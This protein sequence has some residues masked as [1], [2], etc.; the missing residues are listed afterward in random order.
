MSPQGADRAQMYT[1]TRLFLYS[2]AAART[3]AAEGGSQELRGSQAT[4]QAHGQT[5]HGPTA[6]GMLCWAGEDPGER[7]QRRNGANTV[8]YR[9]HNLPSVNTPGAAVTTAVIHRLRDGVP[10]GVWL[11]FSPRNSLTRSNA[12]TPTNKSCD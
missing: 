9:T 11:A 1:W 5:S 4:D 12:S 6:A 7:L 2:K 8:T 3:M 10:G